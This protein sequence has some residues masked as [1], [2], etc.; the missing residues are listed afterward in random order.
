MRVGL[1]ADAMRNRWR[2]IALTVFVVGL[3]GALVV[4]R[5]PVSY[6]STTDV[7]LNPTPGN[8]LTTDSARSGDQI[9]VAMQ[10][11]AGLVKS[12]PVADIVGVTVHERVEAAASEV[13]VSVPPN[14]QIVRIEYTAG[15][16]REA[17]RYASAY[18]DALLEYRR[19]QAQSNV[20]GQLDL[21]KQQSDSA[22]AG[23]KKAAASAGGSDPSAEAVAQVQLYTNRLATLQDQIGSL[24]A[25]PIAPGGVV[26]PA[27]LATTADGLPVVLL[28]VVAVLIGLV[29][30][31]GL[32]IWRE[33][34]DDHIRSAAD[35][36]VESLPVMGVVPAGIAHGHS[37]ILTKDGGPM[38]DAYRG[39]RA[40]LYAKA[41]AP[42]VVVVAGLDEHLE[43]AAHRVAV[44]LAA[45]ISVSG[46]S[47]CLVDA[48]LTEGSIR[49]LT[50]VR[51]HRGL[52]DA[53][54]E[55]GLKRVP[56]SRARGG[57]HVVTGGTVDASM[58]EQLASSRLRG[59]LDELGER[60]E[61]VVVASPVIS[62]S[63]STELALASTG[64]VLVAADRRSLR[65]DVRRTMR[66][67]GHLGISVL[68]LVTV[69]YS[70]HEQEQP[71]VVTRAVEAAPVEEA[72]DKRVAKG[73]A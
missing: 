54:H 3:L 10:T 65:D 41:P 36:D 20:T 51:N 50:G 62:L 53:I 68:G 8:A 46:H 15:S 35:G 6:T 71:V 23:L 58:R 12:P 29:L 24:E 48:T 13:E 19:N 59:V 21:L 49:E 45:S 9:N 66:R 57:Y 1:L 39:V 40:S 67:V 61:Y 28:I 60:H 63:E 47:V 26:T 33:R 64:V 22:S 31:I 2:T 56:V 17:Q 30:G 70:R 52:A 34:T 4:L 11:E 5:L 16:A 43:R 55:G 44:N 38:A 69:Q 27:T 73:G 37:G 14:T 72:E 42:A 18:A 25:T 32:A 7:L